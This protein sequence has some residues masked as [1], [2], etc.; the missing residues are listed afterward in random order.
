M[1][2][3]TTAYLLWLFFGFLGAH[4]FYLRKTG[5]GILYLFTCGLFFIG[6]IV[7]LFTL[8]KQVDAY[9]KNPPPK[10][11]YSTTE[12]SNPEKTVHIEYEDN[13]GDYSNR[14]IE[15]KRVYKKNGEQ[16]IDAFC[17]LSDGDRTFRVDRI[18]SMSYNGE[19]IDD[20]DEFLNSLKKKPKAGPSSED[21]ATLAA[22]D[23]E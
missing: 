2:S 3:K 18:I 9:N 22:K 11:S 19:K 14:T 21:L 16:Y 10:R 5:M 20:I 17:Y 15:I 4:K 1:K 13:K 8:G 12:N 7:D 6:W 23:T